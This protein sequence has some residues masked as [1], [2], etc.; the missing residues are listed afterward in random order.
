[1]V[2]IDYLYDL[3]EN[4]MPLLYTLLQ[5]DVSEIFYVCVGDQLVGTINKVTDG[6]QQMNGREMSEEFIK[7]IGNYIERQFSTSNYVNS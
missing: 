3:F 5:S 7:D 2:K 1:M 6:W 4:Q